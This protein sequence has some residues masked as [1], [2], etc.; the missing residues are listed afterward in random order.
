MATSLA[1]RS[2]SVSVSVSVSVS[3]FLLLS[4]I[5]SPPATLPPGCFPY[6]PHTLPPCPFAFAVPVTR[7]ALPPDFC[8]T[9]SLALSRLSV[10]MSSP[11][12]GFLDLP[13]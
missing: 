8:R 13:I 3:F 2:L 10:Q 4:R 11:Q 5:Y 1:D 12:R 7:H 9:L 6:R